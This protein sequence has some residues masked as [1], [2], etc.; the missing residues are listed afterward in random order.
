MKAAI[1]IMIDRC[2]A[3]RLRDL[4]LGLRAEHEPVVRFSGLQQ[5]AVPG[6]VRGQGG[7]RLVHFAIERSKG[8]AQEAMECQSDDPHEEAEGGGFQGVRSAFRNVAQCARWRIAA[9]G[10]LKNVGGI[11]TAVPRT[12][13]SGAS[14]AIAAKLRMRWARSRCAIAAARCAAWYAALMA[15]FM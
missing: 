12:P 3:F 13:K 9:Y 14:L 4:R 5:V 2:S 1:A 8:T 15:G 7:R 11:A 6:Q 10:R